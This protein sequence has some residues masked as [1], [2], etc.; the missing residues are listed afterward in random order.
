MR[1]VVDIFSYWG[2]LKLGQTIHPADRDVL[3]RTKHHF[4]LR[5]LPT[6][7]YGTLRTAP[8]VLLYLSPG[9]S[10]KDL[11]KAKDRTKQREAIKSLL[12][13]TELSKRFKWCKSRTKCFGKWEK[14]RRKVAVLNISPYHSKAFHD[15]GLLAALPSSRVSLEWA[16][17]VLFPEAIARKRI[18]ICMRSA[19]YWGLT[20]GKTEIGW[21]F[22][23]VITRAGHMQK[24]KMRD[25]IVRVVKRRLQI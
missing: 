14:L 25:Q 8:L 23:P 1:E 7:Y 20:Q 13:H 19:S 24:T 2:D 6:P 18:V 12:G 9:L 17:H 15:H 3:Q 4:E 5:C 21:L 11:R 22:A 16:Q 10:K